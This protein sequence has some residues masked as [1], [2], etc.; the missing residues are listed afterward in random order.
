MRAEVLW[1]ATLLG[2]GF[3]VRL[4]AAAAAGLTGMTVGPGDLAALGGAAGAA[5]RRAADLGVHTLIAEAYTE[6]YPHAEP[7][8]PF[9]SSSWTADTFRRTAEV[10][11]CRDVCLVA[12]FK[13]GESFDA[14][15]EWFAAAC[16]VFAADDLTVHLEFSPFPPIGSIAAAWSIVQAA[17]RPNAGITVDSWHFFRGDPDLDRLRTIPGDRITSVQLN[18]GADQLVESLVKDTF[19]HR[20]LPGDGTFDLVGLVHALRSIGG[21]RLVGPEV[22]STEL[23]ATSTPVDL[24]SRAVAACDRVLRL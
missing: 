11:G 5:V 15:A 17:D 16:D 22:L 24:V 7:P 14:L 13:S 8:V 12:P 4:D 6:W 3:D 20:R 1:S 9:E 10:F 23:S 2:A 18:D 19:R 21:L